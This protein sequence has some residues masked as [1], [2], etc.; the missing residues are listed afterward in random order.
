MA[1]SFFHE[2]GEVENADSAVGGQPISWADFTI[3]DVPWFTRSHPQAGEPDPPTLDPGPLP[4][5][6]PPEV[7]RIE[8]PQVR[9]DIA[10]RVYAALGLKHGTPRGD[11]V[12]W[13]S[14]GLI[15]KLLTEAIERISNHYGLTRKETVALNVAL[16]F[17]YREVLEPDG[18][19]L[20]SIM[21]VLLPAAVAAA[22]ILW[23]E[24]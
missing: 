11:L 18:L 4:V 20:D 9:K 24:R 2:E 22:E 23:E 13:I 3:R 10:D 6:D 8:D 19:N 1:S 5:P 17:T 16:F 21:D 14:H 7:L 12:S 15:A